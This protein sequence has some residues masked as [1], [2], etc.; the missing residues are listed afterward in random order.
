MGGTVPGRPP[1]IGTRN[2]GPASSVPTP[3]DRVEAIDGSLKRR[4]R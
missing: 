2:G 4:I 1:R 3:T